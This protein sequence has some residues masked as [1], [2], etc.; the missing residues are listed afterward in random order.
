MTAAP[1]TRRAFTAMLAY[2]VLGAPATARAQPAKK[3]SPRI[4]FIFSNTPLADIEGPQPKSP[5]ARA[6]LEGMR[7]LGWV[8]GQN[9]TIERRTADGKLERYVTLTRELM[10]SSL[11]L[12]VVSGTGGVFKVKEVSDTIPIVMAGG[13]AESLFSAGVAK[14]LARP[15]GTVTGLTTAIP[16]LEDK[17]LQLLKEAVPGA[18]RVAYLGAVA[19]LPSNTEAAARALKVT[20]LPVET[21]TLGGLERAFGD[22]K[23]TRTDAVLVV[24]GP[25]FFWSA[26]QKLSDLAAQ[27]RLPA[28][29]WDRA[30]AEA[31]G[32]LSYGPDY[33]DIDRRAAYHVDKILKGI[34]PGDIPIEQPT[35]FELVVNLKAARALGITIPSSFLARADRVLE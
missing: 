22:L 15:G 25:T 4:A 35:K 7:E 34:K 33:L 12:I 6:F 23:R 10:G 8:D 26:R 30:F 17:R 21:A 32:L 29:Y 18:S 24:W 2:G 11:D 14:S 16:G 1:P 20:V 28:I 13:I 27:E 31:G 9:I 3:T 19:P 5:Y